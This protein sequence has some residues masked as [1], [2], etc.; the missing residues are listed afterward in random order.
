MN[1]CMYLT[2]SLVVLTATHDLSDLRGRGGGALPGPM[3]W[4]QVIAC[5]VL[6]VM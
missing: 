6:P 3:C 4:E 5:P 1:E 2:M